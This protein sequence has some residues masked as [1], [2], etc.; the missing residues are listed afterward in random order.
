[1]ISPNGSNCSVVGPPG[2][3]GIW[4]KGQIDVP[5]SCVRVSTVGSLFDTILMVFQDKC[6]NLTCVV[7]N[8]NVSPLVRTSEVI[9]TAEPYTLYHLFIGGVGKATGN[10]S[11]TVDFVALGEPCS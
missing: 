10:F 6:D 3:I 5:A 2:T 7:A 1:M 9:F 8:D 4:F 11:F